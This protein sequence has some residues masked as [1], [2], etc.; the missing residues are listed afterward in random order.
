MKHAQSVLYFF[1]FRGIEI[2]LRLPAPQ[3]SDGF[4]QLLDNDLELG[5][6][7]PQ[8]RVVFAELK[9]ALNGSMD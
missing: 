9:Q 8:A 4:C 7:L 3:F 6:C 5:R 1:E 2:V